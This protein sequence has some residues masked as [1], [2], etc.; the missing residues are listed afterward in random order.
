MIMKIWVARDKDGRIYAYSR[1]PTK[2]FSNFRLY[3]G[4]TL[5]LKDQKS[6]PLLSFDNSPIEVIINMKDNQKL[7]AVVKLAA[8]AYCD[9]SATLPEDDDKKAAA[10]R[11]GANFIIQEI[12]NTLQKCKE[13]SHCVFAWGYVVDKLK[14]LKGEYYEENHV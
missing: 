11:T 5:F 7:K 8:S 14:E 2:F 4:Q 9:Y 3:D 13:E 1:K 6:Y 12:E 10:F